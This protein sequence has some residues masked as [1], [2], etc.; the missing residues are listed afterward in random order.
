MKSTAGVGRHLCEERL[1]RIFS[2]SFRWWRAA[3]P[4]GNAVKITCGALRTGTLDSALIQNVARDFLF[5]FPI[6]SSQM[7]GPVR[8]DLPVKCV[9]NRFQERFFHASLSVRPRWRRESCEM[10]C[11]SC[12]SSRQ[13]EC[14]ASHARTVSA[15]MLQPWFFTSFWVSV[16]DIKRPTTGCSSSFSP[17]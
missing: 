12:G 1:P 10:P 17:Q 4:H 6:G 11:S 2:R 8:V 14:Q 3:H 13:F 7:A 15:A 5:L 9:R 16:S